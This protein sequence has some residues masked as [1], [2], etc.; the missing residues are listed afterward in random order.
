MLSVFEG[1]DRREMPVASC[2]LG[3]DF[4]YSVVR[5]VFEGGKQTCADVEIETTWLSAADRHV[6]RRHRE[7]RIG[8]LWRCA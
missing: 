3:P 2:I 5:E 4:A 1:E 8:C 6:N 7:C